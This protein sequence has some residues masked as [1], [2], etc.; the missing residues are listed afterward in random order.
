MRKIDGSSPRVR[1]TSRLNMS[2]MPD[3]R[4][5]PAC[6]GNMDTSQHQQP[7]PSVHPR[8][9]GEHSLPPVLAIYS[10]GSSP[11]VRGTCLVDVKAD[12]VRR[13]IPACAGNMT[14][15]C[16]GKCCETV[17]P[18]VCG[19]HLPRSLRCILAPGS[20]PRVRGTWPSH[21]ES[22][23][24]GRFIPA[25]AGN[26]RLAS[27]CYATLRF[28]PACAGNMSGRPRPAAISSVHPRVCGEHMTPIASNGYKL[29]SSPRVR[30]TCLAKP[31]PFG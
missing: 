28:I 20:S 18:R 23:Q 14:G 16:R 13:F 1:G 2:T 10:A 3:R 5:I 29:G 30:G 8:V 25:C 24:Y 4:F 21:S 11:R 15:R 17:H 6:A 12:V 9:C 19:E 22:A 26:M 31:Q 7:L 27:A